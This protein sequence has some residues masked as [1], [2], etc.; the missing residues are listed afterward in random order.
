[1]A[2]KVSSDASHAGVSAKWRVTLDEG[3]QDAELTA[4]I[5]SEPDGREVARHPRRGSHRRGR[6][7]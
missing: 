2:T 4:R 7:S 3:Q 5:R 1:M 6:R